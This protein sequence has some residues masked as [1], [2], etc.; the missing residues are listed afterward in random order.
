MAIL[1]TSPLRFET[2]AKEFV[3]VFIQP[4]RDAYAYRNFKLFEDSL[5][6]MRA[7]RS[8][9]KNKLR[10]WGDKGL[11]NMRPCP[12]CASHKF[13]PRLKSPDDIVYE[14]CCNCRF[15]F[16][17]PAPCQSAYNAMYESGYDGLLTAWEKTKDENGMCDYRIEKYFGL[18]LIRRH[19]KGGKFLDYGCGSGWVLRLARRDYDVTGMDID[20]N[21][22]ARIRSLLN[23][24]SLIEGDISEGLPASLHGVFDVIH[25]NQNL[26]HILE[27]RRCVA[28]WC[29]GLKPGGFLFIACP[30]I[31]SFAF[32][33]LAGQNSMA[34]LTHVS[35]FSL[36]TIQYLLESEGFEVVD[37]GSYAR[38]I[39]VYEYWQHKMNPS[40]HLFEHRHAYLTSPKTV[41]ALGSPLWIMTELYFYYE[42]VRRKEKFGNYL[43]CLARKK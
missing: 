17:N 22:L 29:K 10:E 7:F 24:D 5:N 11:L 15:V 35:L 33:V 36:P 6:Y 21:Q 13:E 42:M 12:L 43:Y 26:E 38:D 4:I 2:L 8:Y 25:S 3:K 40:P 34:V 18:D 32:D 30:S 28:E 39:T 23:I 16:M 20:P 27:P 19:Q 41:I 9:S 14:S 31:D 1:Y 37:R